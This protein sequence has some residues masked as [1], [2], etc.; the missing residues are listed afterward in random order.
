M[1]GP[2]PGL[3]PEAEAIYNELHA[4]KLA[5]FALKARI[6]R[7]ASRVPDRHQLERALPGIED[8]ITNLHWAANGYFECACARDAGREYG[9]EDVDS[10][11]KG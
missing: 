7:M 1:S 10:K 6:A 3:T 5:A 2:E 4:L 8:S 9:K 11:V